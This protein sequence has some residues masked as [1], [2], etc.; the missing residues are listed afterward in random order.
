M[1]LLLICRSI[2]LD[3]GASTYSTASES[4]YEP[5][6]PSELQTSDKPHD[7]KAVR[8]ELDAIPEVRE[9]VK[10]STHDQIESSIAHLKDLDPRESMIDNTAYG[11]ESYDIQAESVGRDGGDEQGQY[12]AVVMLQNNSSYNYV[13]PV[14]PSNHSKRENS[15]II[16]PPA[17]TAT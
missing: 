7:T 6:D 14:P 15:Y 17:D 9:E 4:G 5:V 13:T 1:V 2:H 16:V 3:G 12:E 10:N 8:T 11:R